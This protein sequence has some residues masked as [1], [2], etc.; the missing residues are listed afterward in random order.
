MLPM[1][2]SWPTAASR[3]R[4]SIAGTVSERE[5]ES[6]ISDWQE[7]ALL[8]PL[9]LFSTTTLLRNVLMPPLLLIERVFI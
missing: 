2:A 3:V 4:M 1:R 5:M 8:A 9:A 7:T 6:S